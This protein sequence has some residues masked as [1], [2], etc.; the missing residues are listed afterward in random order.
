[1]GDISMVDR[2]PE[3]VNRIMEI[4]DGFNSLRNLKE[5][6]DGEGANTTDVRSI[7]YAENFVCLLDENCIFPEII[8]FD[9]G[10]VGLFW[11][12]NG[13]FATLEFI[14]DETIAYYIK[15]GIQILEGVTPFDGVNI[16]DELNHLRFKESS[17][18][19]A[20]LTHSDIVGRVRFAISKLP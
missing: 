5:N 2:T 16:P 19:Q 20:N 15:K 1:M 9:S 12:S 6:W 7:S 10:N 4:L 8:N 17:A 13:L 11:Y 3:F 14:K 18:T